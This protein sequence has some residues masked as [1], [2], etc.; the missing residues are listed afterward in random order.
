MSIH[1]P[2][3]KTNALER[4]VSDCEKAVIIHTLLKTKGDKS[5]AAELLGI[6]ESLLTKKIHQ[7]EIDCTQF[8]LK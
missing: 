4:C 3:T 7:Y 1:I 5:Q 6:K 8:E 2:D